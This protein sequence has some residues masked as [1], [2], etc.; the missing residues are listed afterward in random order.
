MDPTQN[1][2]QFRMNQSN[3]FQGL[4][5]QGIAA[6][7][8]QISSI[9]AHLNRN[10]SNPSQDSSSH[11]Y[12]HPSENTGIPLI[13]T[14][15]DGKN[16]SSWSN[17]MLLALKSKN[18][19]KFVDGSLKKPDKN[20]PLFELW[21]R[22]NTYVLAW[23]KISLNP[24]ITRSV[25]WNKVAYE[26][27]ED[28][29]H[30]YHEGDR[31]RIA[32]LQEELYGTRQG[33]MSVTQYFTK[34][35]SLWEE[36]DDFRPI[37]PCN[38]ESVCTCGLGEMR[39]YRME[40]HVTR[41]LR[42]LNE[43]FANVRA[44]VMLMEPLPDLK[45]V[46]SM[47]TRQERQNQTMD[48]TIDPKI[49]LHSTNSFNTAET[50]QGRGRGKGRGGR[51]QG[52]G[53]GQT[54][55]GERQSRS[56]VLTKSQPWNKY[57]I[58]D[59]LS[60]K[61]I[62]AA[63]VCG[64][65]Y[66]LN[67]DAARSEIVQVS[68]KTHVDM[69]ILNISNTKL[70]HF[71]LG[72]AP[73]H[74]MKEMKKIF[75]FIHC[76]SDVQPC[77]SCHLARQK[78]LSFNNSSTVSLTSFDLIHVDVWGPLAIPST[79]G[80]RYFLTIVDDKTRFT[81]VFFMK[82]KTEVADLIKFF[83]NF[84]KTQYD[85]KIRSIRSDNGTEFL[86]HSF[87]NETGIL[88]QRSCVE[89][90][91]QNGIVERKHQHILEITRAIFFHSNVPKCFWQYTVSYSVHIMNRLPS[92]FLNNLSPYQALH[93]SLPD[94]SHLRVFGCLAYASTLQANRKKLDPRSRRCA[95]L[96]FKEGTKGYLLID[97]K[98]R[99]I[100]TSRDVSFYEDHFPYLSTH[101]DQSTHTASSIQFKT[102]P[103]AYD[104][105]LQPH[106]THTNHQASP[107]SN[108]HTETLNNNNNAPQNFNSAHTPPIQSPQPSQ[109]NM[110]QNHT[111][112]PQHASPL[113]LLRKS[114]RI[115]RAPSHLQ[116]YHCLNATTSRLPLRKSES[117][118]ITQS[119]WVDAIKN[120]LQAL[121]QSQTW[122]LTSL[123]PGKKAI[124]N[125]WVFK[126]KYNPDGSIERYK[127]RLVAKG[128]TQ[129]PGIDY[130]DT[131]S[132]VMKLGS[133]RVVLAVAAAKGWFL[134]QI[135]VNTAFLHG[136]LDE[137]VYMKPP[138]GL[139]VKAGQVCKLEKSLYGLKQ[140]SRQW[141]T[142]LKSVLVELGFVQSKADYSLFTKQTESGFT[143]LLVYVDDLILA[144]NN[145]GEINAVKTVLDDR[146]KIKD[147]GDLKFFIG[148]E[149]A[150]SKEGILLNQRKYAMDILKD[151]GFENCKPAST[152]MDYSTKLS[153]TEGVP[154]SDSTEYRKLV[155]KLLYLTNTRPDISFAIGK[156]SQYLDHP[157]TSH[158]SAV[159][160]I[161]RYIK[162]SPATGIMFSATSDLC[163]T[164]FADSDWAACPDSRRSVTAYCFYIGTALV[165][166]KS[167]KQ[168]TVACSSAEAE[169]RAL[170][171]ATKEAIWLSFILK[172]L[173][174]PLTKPIST[175][176]DSQSA[177]HIASNPVFHERT[178]HIEA[179]CHI[180]RDK[181]QE[182]LIHLLPISTTEQV[183]DILTKPLPPS[184]FSTLFGKL[185]LVN[186][187][188]PNLREGVT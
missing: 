112:A 60:K 27:W 151:A 1:S 134:K 172:D 28:L 14:I 160:R 166:W 82:N 37:P 65:L 58:K 153:K 9:Q 34:L 156:L 68:N 128:F 17:A 75:K 141:N 154:L 132:P 107:A 20:D 152:P 120:E 174:M 165:S 187:H 114:T 145:L 80:H 119:C 162:A 36:F 51:F 169:Y 61:T 122:K 33:E 76:D 22:C 130:R 79:G 163:A 121:E 133:L 131:F 7:L 182:G 47:M 86:M 81:W 135:D 78:R 105:I 25:M 110:P 29:K 38:C 54:G 178:K 173:G 90:P 138:Q 69:P 52:S 15:L 41:F 21:D 118:A 129:V 127:A 24:E 92:N 6:F 99:E 16:Y 106:T 18:K 102:D 136:D 30:R 159:H 117:E 180:V 167:K 188:T 143:A 63:R 43:Q 100:F 150:R 186:L 109:T 83:V 146:F 48:D 46:F 103:F 175:Y 42:G 85:S 158:L 84:V 125:K 55:R 123:P 144:G 116:D 95:F 183:A 93:N 31:F 155:G 13:P 157:T 62:G 23:I 5:P 108:S 170:A 104:I 91:Q 59:L 147:I 124:G 137:E 89:T 72:H 177:I 57:L 161:L 126:V 88:H 32:E 12:L 77:D 50:S 96:G 87:F 142:K 101:P 45:A 53:R 94:I 44:Q 10:G 26:L 140:A 8:N 74:R 71:R 149:V 11:F 64:G 73:F 2:E 70:W 164:G 115:R 4:D 39:K 148:M 49:L 181:F 113:P 176:C 139:D 184:M 40:D 56:T 3:S 111:L 179:D 19:L 171:A 185:G 67:C 168:V 66:T 98:T 35:K 97:L